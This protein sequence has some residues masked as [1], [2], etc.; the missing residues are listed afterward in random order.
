MDD[1]KIFEQPLK[2][3]DNQTKGKM[4][5][6]VGGLKSDNPKGF[7]DEMVSKYVGRTGHNQFI[8]IHMDNPW[9]RVIV[10]GINDIPLREMTEDD[11][12]DN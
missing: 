3:E 12:I 4:T 2:G 9:T 7:M 11:S 10:K 8:E 1:I 5:I 6:L